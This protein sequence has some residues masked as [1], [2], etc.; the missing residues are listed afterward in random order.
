MPE[1]VQKQKH[2]LDPR[3]GDRRLRWWSRRS[4]RR[5]RAVR[6]TPG[7]ARALP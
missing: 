4:A 1:P 6:S 5:S 3:F 2:G 7:Q